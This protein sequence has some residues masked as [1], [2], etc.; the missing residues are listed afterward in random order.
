MRTSPTYWLI[1]AMTF[2]R[3]EFAATAGLGVD[4][5]YMVS[6]ARIECRLFRR[7]TRQLVAVVGR[8]SHASDRITLGAGRATHRVVRVVPGVGLAFATRRHF[9]SRLF[10][11]AGFNLSP[12]ISVTTGTRVLPD[13]SLDAALLEA[14]LCM[15]RALWA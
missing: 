9:E 12:V 2:L 1:T 3:L 4:E 11:V 15:L 14:A 6:R 8:C 7:S 10:V 13:G 5:S